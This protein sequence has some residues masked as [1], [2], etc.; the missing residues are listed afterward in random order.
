MPDKKEYY[1][2]DTRAFLTEGNLLGKS[3]FLAVMDDE[4]CPKYCYISPVKFLV[5]AENLMKAISSNKIGGS[6]TNLGLQFFD[7]S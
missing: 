2:E 7:N 6:N 4:A 5:S 3:G 1:L